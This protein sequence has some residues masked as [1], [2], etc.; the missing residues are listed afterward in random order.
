MNNEFKK[1]SQGDV[2]RYVLESASSG[3]TSSGS[4]ASTSMPIGGTRKRGDNL[5]AQESN[6]D[7]VPASTPRNFVAKNAK[8]GGAGAHKDKKR[9][10]KQGEVKHKKPYMEDYSNSK[11]GY[12]V[13]ENPEWYND[14][15]NGM[16][17]SQLKSLVKHAAKLRQAVKAMQAQG[18]TLEPWQQSKI[19]KAADYLDA[20]FDAVDDDYD[21]G[22]EQ[23]VAEGLA[24]DEAE[25]EYGGW[26]AELVNQINYNTFEVNVKNARSKESANFIIR[27]VDMVSYGPTLSVETFDVHDLQT[28][29]TQ[30][31]TNDDPAPEGPIAFAISALFYDSKELQKKLKN[32][33]DTNNKKG[34]D[35]LPGLAQRRSIGQEVDADAYV[36]AGEKTQ[37]A[38]SKMKKGVA[39]GLS[40]RDQKDVA[41]IKTAIERLQA[42]LKQPNADKDAIQQSIAHERKRLA[43]YKEGV[44]E[45]FP[46]P[47]SGS[48]G[49]SKEDKRIAVALRKKHIPTTP[50]KKKEQGVAEGYDS[51]DLA[52]AVYA[53]FERIYPNLA[54]RANERTVHAAIMDVLN[55]GGDSNPG[56]LAQDVARAVKRDIEQGVAEEWSKK[57]K[58]SINCSH[59]KGFSQKAHCAGKKKHNESVDSVME[60]TCPDCGMCQT[61]GNLNEIA[62]GAKDSNGFTKCWPGHRAAGT[63]KGKNGGQVRNCVPNEAAN[64]AQQAAIAIA[65]KKAGKKPKSES[66]TE[67]FNSTTCPKHGT[68][69]FYG[70]HVPPCPKCGYPELK[71]REEYYKSMGVS[72][73]DD[74]EQ[75]V[76]EGMDPDQRARLDDLIDQYRTAS[77][78]EAYYGLNDEYG[79]PDEII[80]Q[81][82]QEFG[83]NIASKVEAGTDKMHYPRQGHSQSYDRLSQKD[84]VDRTTK[85]G[86]MFK[87]DSDF[88]KN[89][90]AA[91]FRVNGKKGPLPL[92]EG[93]AYMMELAAK[94]AEKIPKNAP[95]DVYIKDFERSNAPQ[96]KGKSMEKRRQM[97]VAAS[98]GAKNPSKKK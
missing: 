69:E 40:K 72:H 51:E 88:R 10:E 82:R 87:Q 21:M 2:T 7:T 23:G 91:K 52:N 24:Q 68:Y 35:M 79:D 85:G 95:V 16:T 42:Q 86:K 61:H 29:Q 55:Y 73:K 65:M 20:V 37:A 15:A 46:N 80:G 22:E 89:N 56:A 47:G 71:S 67:D 60:M 57:Y 36:D 12:K 41:A 3:G 70:R 9:A 94:L 75:G 97:A 92:P 28:G 84:P 64:P 59:P 19:T 83:D 25:E 13:A 62:K 5:I 4:I 48:T 43:L 63:K 18:N 76:A 38:M 6:K 98:Y 44:A 50:N 77:D 58:S 30:S 49:S 32:I 11:Q 27:P 17:T 81:I 66:V 54:R 93:D 90:I 45:A 31:W 8:A 34:Q 39:E 74:K 96:F 33:I 53:E 14:E 1:L 78:P 26:R